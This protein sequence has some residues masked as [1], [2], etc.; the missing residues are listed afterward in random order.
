ML[1]LICS[2]PVS[3]GLLLA[4]FATIAAPITINSSNMQVSANYYSGASMV[5]N[6]VSTA[7]GSRSLLAVEGAI[8]SA[9]DIN[10]ADTG[11]GGLFDFD[12][13]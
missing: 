1:R 9:L 3:S 4:S 11:S 12:F 7:Y 10:W 2:L 6:D 13:N 8:S 5:A